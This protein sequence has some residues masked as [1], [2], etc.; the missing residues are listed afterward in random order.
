VL[1]G[2]SAAIGVAVGR[3]WRA[4]TFL[5]VAIVLNAAYWVIAQGLGGILTGSGTDPNAGPLFTLLA[6]ALYSVVGPRQPA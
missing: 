1:A 3:N 2:L 5:V 4:R 6:F